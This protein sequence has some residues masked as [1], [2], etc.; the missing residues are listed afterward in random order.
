[1]PRDHLDKNHAGR[2]LP[3]SGLPRPVGLSDS[4]RVGMRFATG[5][6]L[7]VTEPCKVGEPPLGQHFQEAVASASNRKSRL[8]CRIRINF[9]P[10]ATLTLFKPDGPVR[11]KTA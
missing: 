6:C 5:V 3:R 10:C 1:M 9:N 11:G 7:A 8:T 4:E 2:S